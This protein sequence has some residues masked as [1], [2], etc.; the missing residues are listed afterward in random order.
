M[1]TVL[2]G[3]SVKNRSTSEYCD[4]HSFTYTDSVDLNKKLVVLE[5]FYNLDR[6][7]VAFKGKTPYEALRCKLV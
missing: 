3:N 5:R 7:H 6:P 1:H 2:Q 4:F